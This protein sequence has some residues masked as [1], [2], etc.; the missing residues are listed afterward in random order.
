MKLT[1]IPYYHLG[2]IFHLN[3]TSCL[4]KSFITKQT[5]SK[6]FPHSPFLRDQR[7]SLE[8]SSCRD[9]YLFQARPVPNFSLLL[10]TLTFFEEYRPVILQ[11]SLQRFV[12]WFLK[13]P[14]KLCILAEIQQRLSFF[15]STSDWEMCYG[16]LFQYWSCYYYLLKIVHVQFLHCIL[17]E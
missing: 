10:V 2:H 1:S 4:K 15:L 17:N 14:I 8:Q 16:S 11:C 6:L 3:F 7:S 5:K 13:I 9:S 12:W